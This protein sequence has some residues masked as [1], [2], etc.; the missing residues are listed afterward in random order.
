MDNYCQGTTFVV[1]SFAGF[2]PEELLGDLLDEKYLEDSDV[3]KKDAKTQLF[4]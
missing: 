1:G 4:I 2:S 3:D